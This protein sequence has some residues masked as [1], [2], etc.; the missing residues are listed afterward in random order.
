MT[1]TRKE[2]LKGAGVAA[3]GLMLPHELSARPVDIDALPD[4][5]LG[6]L[7]SKDELWAWL[8]QLAGWCPALTGGPGHASFVNFLDQELRRSNLTPQRKTFTLP[9]WELKA[10][11]LVL[12]DEKLHA[13]GY[14]PYSGPTPP[15]GVTAP[16]YN[17]G[18]AP[19]FDFSG[20]RG[21]VVLM[22]MAPVAATSAGGGRARLA[23]SPRIHRI[24]QSPDPGG[25]RCAG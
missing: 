18:T 19:N 16:L 11:G 12:G 17:A 20:A 8:Q 3:L 24:R 14:R 25:M 23:S 9:Y 21:K 7:P 6:N 10:Y 4:V 5:A 13:A 15:S 2:F 1:I 22:E